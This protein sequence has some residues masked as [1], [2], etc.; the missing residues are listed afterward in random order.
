MK[1]LAF[2]V[3][4]LAVFLTLTLAGCPNVAEQRHR[5]EPDA[6]AGT[7]SVILRFGT[8]TGR[9]LLPDTFT[10]AAHQGA[11]SPVGEPAR[12]PV[13]V[14]DDLTQPITLR[15]GDWKLEID[16]YAQAGDEYPVATG[17][18]IFTVA[19]GEN[20]EP[21]EVPLTFVSMAGDGTFTWSI[22][23]GFG[24]NLHQ[25][26]VI[27]EYLGVPRANDR[28]FPHYLTGTRTVPAG[29]Y[30][31]TVRMEMDAITPLYRY[32]DG[33]YIYILGHFTGARRAIWSDVLHVYPRQT[34]PMVLDF[35][36]DDYFHAVT[37]A[38]LFG[39][40]TDWDLGNLDGKAMELQPDGTLVWTGNLWRRS[41]F[42]FSLTDTSYWTPATHYNRS[43]GAWF[44]PDTNGAEVSVGGYYGAEFMR[45]HH[46]NVPGVDRAWRIDVMPGFYRIILDPIEREFTVVRDGP[47]DVAEM[48][49][50]GDMADDWSLPGDKMTKDDDGIFAWSGSVSANSYFRFSLLDTTYRD[51]EEERWNGIWLAPGG[52]G[53]PATVGIHDNMVHIA[54]NTSDSWRIAAAG[55]YV[56]IV[57]LN[58][59]ELIVE[60]PVNV[61]G[62]A[63]AGPPS[64]NANANSTYSFSATL[65]GINYDDPTVEVDWEV[66]GNTA[67]G[68]SFGTGANRHV[69]TIAADEEGPLTI[70]AR[71]G[72]VQSLPVTVN[73]IRD[74]MAGERVI[75][76]E[77]TDQGIRPDE[78]GM[79]GEPMI[80]LSGDDS[81][82]FRV[83]SP[84]PSATR[85]YR[86]IVSGT[87]IHGDSL[88]ITSA[89][90]RNFVIDPAYPDTTVSFGV[91]RHS[92]R[93]VVFIGGIPWSMS[94][95]RHFTVRQ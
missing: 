14:P 51:D 17:E 22:T 16:L 59:F 38:W 56:L 43:G 35:E 49:L 5:A 4:T 21:L 62:V 75:E 24:A 37:Q 90:A 84:A 78:V 26:E 81:V 8:P 25:V 61:T 32:V 95:L 86:W 2:A 66:S 7:G 27:L 70:R 40:M 64:R 41:Y 48:W 94:E 58:E 91:G 34:T 68:T 57:D 73:V 76:F 71:V 42:R 65:S 3:S 6:D 52:V 55:Y 33:E 9:T 46:G 10:F 69:L 67:T 53:V 39:D 12:D 15:V 82:T 63:I 92:V 44:V 36:D 20:N 93:L 83:L 11:F 88:T 50:V 60:R 29:F 31:V 79:D 19:G 74:G 30:L 45:L 85:T 18:L 80:S 89:N 72:E 47:V 87:T 23:H 28:N 1:R 77:V 13:S 54:S